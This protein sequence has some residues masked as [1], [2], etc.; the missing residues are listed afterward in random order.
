[1]EITFRIPALKQ[2]ERI[3]SRHPF[4]RFPYRSAVRNVRMHPLPLILHFS[5]TSSIMSCMTS[6]AAPRSSYPVR[7]P[8]LVFTKSAPASIQ[9]RQVFL[10][11]SSVRASVSKITF[12]SLPYLCAVSAQAFRSAVTF[13]YSP[14]RIRPK[15][16]TTSISVTVSYPA[17][18][19]TCAVLDSVELVPK[20][21]SV[22]GQR[23]V[24]VPSTY[25][26]QSSI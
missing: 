1:M 7:K 5:P 13:S 20:G 2:Q 17:A 9:Q 4:C 15:F 11:C 16:A 14:E 10:I 25:G 12:N 3:C 6:G 21:K 24:S 26:V 18:I 8:V 22:T 19:S 23:P